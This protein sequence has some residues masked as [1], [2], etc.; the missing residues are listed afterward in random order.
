MWVVWVVL[1]GLILT[2]LS[3]FG[4]ILSSILAPYSLL[5]WLN[6]LFCSGFIVAFSGHFVLLAAL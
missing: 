1:V 6:T 4:S 2:S 3:F 5:F